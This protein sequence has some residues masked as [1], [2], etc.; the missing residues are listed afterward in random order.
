[1]RVIH[2]NHL[3]ALVMEFVFQFNICVMVLLIVLMVMMKI[4]D[5]VLQVCLCIN[6]FSK[7]LRFP[8]ACYIGLLKIGAQNL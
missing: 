1:M 5:Y 8:P 3:N 2:T 6:F 7:H 4:P